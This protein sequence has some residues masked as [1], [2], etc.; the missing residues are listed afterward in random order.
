[1]RAQQD[2]I[3]RPVATVALTVLRR[4]PSVPLSP[5]QWGQLVALLFPMVQSTRA[6]SASLARTFYASQTPHPTVPTFDP[7]AYDATMLAKTLE[8]FSRPRLAAPATH[9][10]G[11]AGGASALVRHV[12]QANREWVALAASSDKARFA[13]VDPYG[14]TC[15]FC[16]LLISRGPVYLSQTSGAFQSHPDCTCVAVPVFDLDADWPGKDQF[17]EAEEQYARATAGTSGKESIRAFR[18][19]VAEDG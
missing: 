7:P 2:A 4:L 13:R 15:A 17:L 12:E 10:Q 11:A 16:R 9:E 1:M 8:T 19:A 18:R 6:K 3:N 5:L 14:E